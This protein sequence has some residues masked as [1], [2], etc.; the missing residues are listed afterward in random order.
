M[1]EIRSITSE[2]AHM[3]RSRVFHGF[4]RDLETDDAS[5]ERFEAIFDLDRT[6][7]AFDGDE[8]VGTCA[9]FSLGLTVP[10]GVELPMGGTTVVTVRPTHRRQG[11]LRALMSHHLDEIAERGEPLAGLW[12]SEGSIYGRFGYGPATHLWEAKIHARHVGFRGGDH[13]GSAS[14]LDVEEAGPSMR[15]VYERA[16]LRRPGML[17][18]SEAWWEHRVLA[19]PES[20]RDG[21]SSH[22]YVVYEEGGEPTGYALYRQKGKWLDSL[23]DGEVSVTEVMATTPGAHL[24]LWSF[25]LNIDLFPNVEYWNLPVDDPL[26]LVLDNHRRVPP[27]RG[28]PLGEADGRAR[29]SERPRLRTRRCRRLHRLRRHPALRRGHVSSRGG[30]GRGPL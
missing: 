25:L 2:D 10:G 29:G 14:L 19:D 4:G 5:K 7:A 28:R 3:F 13:G 1:I 16:R 27:P 24:G 9:A 30:R 8:I 20:W 15:L 26:P 21:K 6:L 12:A 17:T 18:R 23:P 11:V 22:R